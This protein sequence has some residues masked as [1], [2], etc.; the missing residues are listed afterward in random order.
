MV[1]GHI[2]YVY[3]DICIE[4]MWLMN[5][6]DVWDFHF[7]KIGRWWD[8]NTEIDIVAIDTSENNIIFAECK[9]WTSSKVGIDVLTALEQKAQK[10]EWKKEIRKN[11]F[12]LFAV[13]GFTEEL[14]ALSNIRKDLILMS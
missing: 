6:N 5:S 9:Y 14:I 3:E 10:V 11:Y 7:D 8:K 2:A 4:K 13:N 1:D 12:V